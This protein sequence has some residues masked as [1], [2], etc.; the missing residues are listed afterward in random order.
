MH[1][2]HTPSSSNPCLLVRKGYLSVADHNQADQRDVYVGAQ[3]LIMVNLIHLQG[4]K[5]MCF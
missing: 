3:R 2:P 5:S 4:G 1:R